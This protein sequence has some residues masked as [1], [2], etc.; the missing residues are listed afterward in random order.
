[1]GATEAEFIAALAAEPRELT[2]LLVFAD[3]L[4]ERG[5]PR[6][7]G[8]RLLAAPRPDWRRI[9]ELSS[10]VEY[11]QAWVRKFR[12]GCG[13]VVRLNSGPFAGNVGQ[14]VGFCPN[15]GKIVVAVRVVFEGLTLDAEV[16]S[17]C[18]EHPEWKE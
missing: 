10:P 16:D 9:A 13:S 4:D 1:M 6:A 18:I 7:E 12:C 8:L 3:W 11:V 14:V 17:G 2:T 15:D 5:D